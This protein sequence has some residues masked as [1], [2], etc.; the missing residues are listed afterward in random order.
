MQTSHF[1]WVA[2]QA[3][4]V[5]GPA[6]SLP[7]SFDQCPPARAAWPPHVAWAVT[8]PLSLSLTQL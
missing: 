5:H 1:K 3:G 8:E 6:R 4:W 2:G 7:W